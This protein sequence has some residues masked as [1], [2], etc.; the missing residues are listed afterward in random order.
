MC[1]VSATQDQLAQFRRKFGK[2]QIFMR[3]EAVAVTFW[4]PR[5]RRYNIITITLGVYARPE[6]YAIRYGAAPPS[7]VKLG[8]M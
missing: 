4:V 6:V 3:G 7:K 2:N 5:R 8:R 1:F